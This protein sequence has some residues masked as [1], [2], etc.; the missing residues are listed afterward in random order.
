MTLDAS[1]ILPVPSPE[2]VSIKQSSADQAMSYTTPL[3]AAAVLHTSAPVSVSIKRSAKTKPSDRNNMIQSDVIRVLGLTDSDDC[4]SKFN[5]GKKLLE[6]TNH[7]NLFSEM[8]V[9]FH[10]YQQANVQSENIL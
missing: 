4:R 3:W 6:A 8:M 1:Q 10:D 9:Y 2:Q 5:W 7:F